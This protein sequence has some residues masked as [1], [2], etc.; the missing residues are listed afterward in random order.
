MEG[1]KHMSHA[2][3]RDDEQSQKVRFTKASTVWLEIES[4]VPQFSRKLVWTDLIIHRREN[5]T[6]WLSQ[7]S[8]S[9]VDSARIMEPSRELKI[10][11]NSAE[12]WFQGQ[13]GH[14]LTSTWQ[15]PFFSKE[16]MWSGGATGRRWWC[17]KNLPDLRR[18]RDT[19]VWSDILGCVVDE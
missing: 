4:H 18:A 19:L 12:F 16:G 13:V 11:A 7:R 8:A 14:A 9:T 10:G 1:H 2:N 6:S 5:N 15:V 17:H 3:D